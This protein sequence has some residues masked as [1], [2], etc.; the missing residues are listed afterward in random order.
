MSRAAPVPCQHQTLILSPVQAVSKYRESKD[1]AAMRHAA[2]SHL[3]LV[4]RQW[5][6]ECVLL[7]GPYWDAQR[8]V[9]LKVFGSTRL[10]VQGPGMLVLA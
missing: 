8:H 3:G 2:I 4:A 10:G 1:Q 9:E 6:R 7:H 5:A